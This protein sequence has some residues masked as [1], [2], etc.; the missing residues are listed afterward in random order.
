MSCNHP[1]AIYNEVMHKLLSEEVLYK[2]AVLDEPEDALLTLERSRRY[3]FEPKR[4]EFVSNFA[5][6]FHKLKTQ[7]GI[8]ICGKYAYADRANEVKYILLDKIDDSCNV[9]LSWRTGTLS[10]EAENLI[11]LVPGPTINI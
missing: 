9:V 5:T 4:I 11:A 3:G 8:S 6:L 2:V 10:R 1:L 7:R